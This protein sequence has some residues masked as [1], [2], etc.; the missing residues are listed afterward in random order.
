MKIKINGKPAD[1]T[2]ETEKTVSEVVAGIHQ[3][4]EGSGFLVSG[5]EIDGIGYGSLSLDTALALPVEGISVIDIKT[6]GW[7]DLLMEALTG[8][9]NDLE[10]YERADAAE[11]KKFTEQWAA[12]A[13]ALF[14]KDH[15]KNLYSLVFKT[16]EDA[17]SEV[18]QTAFAAAISLLTERIREIKNPIEEMKILHP[19]TEDIAKRLE[20]LPLDMQTGKDSKAAETISIFS[21]LVEKIFRLIFLFRYFK[22]DIESIE[23]PSMNG[24]ETLKIN[25]YIGEFSAALKELISA[26]E[27]KDTILVGDLAEYELAPRLRCLSDALN[28]VNPEVIS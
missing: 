6:S 14:L 25:D 3:W 20:D 15:E 4:L 13:P 27:N 26:F 18:S 12:S 11:R 8:I 23:V 21:S 28:S 19:L 17:S 1:I 16:L 22:T 5:I 10:L 7:A 9:V 2:L 24:T